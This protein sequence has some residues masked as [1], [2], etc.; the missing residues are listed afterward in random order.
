ML[1][2]EEAVAIR[3]ST[4]QMKEKM[5]GAATAHKTKEENKVRFFLTG[6]LLEDSVQYDLFTIT[7]IKL[8]LF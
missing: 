2:R 7:F 3:E 4:L 1:V 6:W 5:V 8:F